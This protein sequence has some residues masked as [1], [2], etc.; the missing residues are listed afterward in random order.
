MKCGKGRKGSVW[1]AGVRAIIIVQLE[2]HATKVAATTFIKT[3]TET[4]I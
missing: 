2:K 1:A 3:H 4:D